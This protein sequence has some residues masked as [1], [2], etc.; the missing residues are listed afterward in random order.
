MEPF[1]ADL[2]NNPKVPKVIRYTIVS[3]VNLFILYLG[4][5]CIIGSAMVIG[6]VFGIIL[7]VLILMAAVYLMRKIHKN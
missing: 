6:K 1:L 3:V 5:S 7:C 2:I 4:I